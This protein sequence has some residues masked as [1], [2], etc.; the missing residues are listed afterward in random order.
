[1]HKLNKLAVLMIMLFGVC[2]NAAPKPIQ[3]K[4]PAKKTAPAKPKPVPKSLAGLVLI[5]DPGHGGEDPG[6]HGVFRGENV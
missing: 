5:L 1:M 6:A 2:V 3:A 4:P